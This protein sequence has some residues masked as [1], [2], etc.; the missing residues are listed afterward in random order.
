MLYVDNTFTLA[1]SLAHYLDIPRHDN[2]KCS[3]ARYSPWWSQDFLLEYQYRRQTLPFVNGV[4]GVLCV[5]YFNRQGYQPPPL[6]QVPTPQH[7]S[8]VQAS[9]ITASRSH[10]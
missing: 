4:T 8:K 1:D 7:D 2:V 9:K 6:W 3:R 10:T 5:L